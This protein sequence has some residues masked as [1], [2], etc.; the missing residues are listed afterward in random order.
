MG[1]LLTFIGVILA[2][3]FYVFNQTI[4]NQKPKSKKNE[5]KRISKRNL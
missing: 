2:Y 1:M 4:N 5:K 3:D